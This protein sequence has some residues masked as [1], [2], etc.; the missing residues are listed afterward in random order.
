MKVRDACQSKALEC[1]S[2]VDQIVYYHRPSLKFCQA[3]EM[4]RI[5][6]HADNSAAALENDNGSTAMTLRSARG[7]A[8]FNMAYLNTNTRYERPY[9]DP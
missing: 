7:K 4:M 6:R 8:L 2:V 5:E 9:K 3:S 1:I